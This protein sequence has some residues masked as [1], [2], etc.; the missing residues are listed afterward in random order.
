[1]AIWAS[2]IAPDGWSAWCRAAA[3][4]SFMPG[5]SGRQGIPEGPLRLQAHYLEG[6]IEQ[7]A[8][9]GLPARPITLAA[10]ARVRESGSL[11]AAAASS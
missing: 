2:F 11:T 3:V 6:I 8:R 5:L 7:F 4:S 1:M 10:A 9:G